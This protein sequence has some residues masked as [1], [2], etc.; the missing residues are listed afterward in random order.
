M[1]IPVSGPH[2]PVSFCIKVK[3]R[4]RADKEKPTPFLQKK[5]RTKKN[6]SRQPVNFY[7]LRGFFVAGFHLFPYVRS[8][9]Y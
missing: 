1:N 9:S 7:E 3:G 2:I 5:L 4:T 6:T 8:S